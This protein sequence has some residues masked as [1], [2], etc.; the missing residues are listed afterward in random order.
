MPSQNVALLKVL[1]PIWEFS[2]QCSPRK[3]RPIACNPEA[4]E[5]VTSPLTT[6]YKCADGTDFPVD[7]R[8]PEYVNL[9]WAWNDHHFPKPVKPFD[10]A[11]T[12]MTEASS[13]RAW[14]DAELRPFVNHSLAPN[15]FKYI[16]RI[17]LTSEQ[18]AADDAK[19]QQFLDRMGGILG[20]WQDFCQ[21]KAEERCNWLRNAGDETSTVDLIDAFG[22]AFHMTMV[23]ARTISVALNHFINFLTTEVGL[24][25]ETLAIELTT[26]GVNETLMADQVL[27]EVAQLARDS[28]SLKD[29]VIANEPHQLLEA[30]SEVDQGPEFLAAFDDYLQRYGSRSTTWEAAVP[31]VRE[32]PEVS[33]G[34]IKNAILNDVP[35]PLEVQ[36]GV[37]KAAEELAVDVE[38][39][40]GADNEK[41]DKFRALLAEA[42]PMVTV[43]E[44]RAFWQLQAYGSLRTAVLSR[45]QRLVDA[46]AIETVEDIF[47]L[48]PEEIDQ[49]LARPGNSAKQLVEQRRQEWEFWYTKTPP[50]FIGQVPEPTQPDPKGVVASDKVL[51]GVGASRGIVTARAR[52]IL[53]L[54]EAA[55]F[56]SGEILVCM[57]TAPPWTILFT[58]A[59]AVVTDTGGVLSHASIASREYGIPCVA[60]VRNGTSILRDGMLITVDGSEGTVTIED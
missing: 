27:W 2:Y 22:Y 28:A 33:L 14:G 58:K 38:N 51:R 20:V 9:R 44:N 18:Q 43:R 25:A 40:L 54:S 36:K 13:R 21:P 17:P 6:V 47:F 3:Y 45:G 49:F 23:S 24:E 26:G 1:N 55:N 35:A 48:E 46:D 4:E 10:A 50:Q 59:A 8:E 16:N 39:R 42:K 29:V 12:L 37:L 32:Q 53:D 19:V 34:F 5:I 30:I 41:R 15:G 56:Q 31:H 11:A 57:M 52:V 7:W 60:A